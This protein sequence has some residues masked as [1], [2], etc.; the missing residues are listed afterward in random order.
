MRAIQLLAADQLAVVDV[1]PK[2][3]GPGEVVVAVRAAALNHRDVWIK[4]G[5]YA[6][7]KWP[8]VPGSDGAGMVQFVGEG[9]DSAWIGREVILNP[10]LAWGEDERAQGSGFEILGLPRDGTLAQEVV[11]PAEQL[12]EKPRHLTW[13]EAAA[14]PLAG[15]TAYRAVE[16]RAA[17][18]PG[19]RVLVTG[20]GGGVAVF[21]L[22]F[23]VAAGAEVWVT[24]SSG[25]KIARAVELGARGGFDYTNPEWATAALRAPGAFD[26]VID[27][28]GGEG[29]GRLI[30]VNAPGGRLVFFGATRGDAALPMR[31]VFWR[32]LT[33]L[34][35][36]MGSPADWQAMLA[37]VAAA[38]IR[39]VVGAVYPM[40]QAERA[41]ALMEE[42]GQFGKIVLRIEA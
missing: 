38:G 7:L 15:L 34:G 3:A 25:A 27:S 14:L 31:K 41:F 10:S 35:T 6:G 28:A 22:Q 30:D 11:V 36:T 1:P 21:A 17:V 2:A 13:E 9:V 26:V 33:L 18:K 12:A 20:I 39:P 23:A 8:C 32:Q 24:S 40:G 42:G 29:F 4:S 16:K 5:K 19:E 37:Q